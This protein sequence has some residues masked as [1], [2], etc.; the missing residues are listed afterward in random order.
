MSHK[1]KIGLAVM[2]ST[3]IPVV[4]AALNEAIGSVESLINSVLPP[5]I[6]DDNPAHRKLRALWQAKIERWKQL[7]AKLQAGRP[8]KGER[9]CWL[10]Y[11]DCTRDGSIHL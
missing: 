10:D 11:D 5:H 8:R 2:D 9:E 4:R 7:R 6:G 1:K 3:D